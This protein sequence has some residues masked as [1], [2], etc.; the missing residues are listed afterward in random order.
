MAR[1][2]FFPCWSRSHDRDVDIVWKLPWWVPEFHVFTESLFR[3]S[4]TA[5][6][7]RCD[8]PRGK[9]WTIHFWLIDPSPAASTSGFEID[10]RP[11]GAV[12]LMFGSSTEGCG[13]FRMASEPSRAR[14]RT[15]VYRFSDF[16]S[17]FQL[18]TYNLYLL[19]KYWSELK[20]CF[21]CFLCFQHVFDWH[22][23][24]V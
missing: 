21:R 10:R 13:R 11:G 14:F 24:V 5:G 2:R 17:L 18:Y 12:R 23:W 16:Y 8:W 7:C 20:W 6:N 4:G 9:G 22:G 19:R 1:Q 3:V 15:E